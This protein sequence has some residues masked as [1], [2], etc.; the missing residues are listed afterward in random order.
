MFS[1]IIVIISIVVVAVAVGSGAQTYSWVKGAQAVEGKVV[2]LV[3]KKKR[4]KKGG[5]GVTYAPRVTYRI[6][7]E[8]RDFV[9]SQS[10]NSPDFAVGDPVRVAV[11]LE[12]GEESIATFGELYGF[13][14]VGTFLGAALAL[15]VMI[16]MNGDK[17][18]RFIH[19]NLNG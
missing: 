3:E 16:I 7:G 2:E 19:P 8:D 17:V 5:T 1:W 4:K 10:S 9:S 12:K 11:N 13:S 6:N 15:A 14:I 18:L